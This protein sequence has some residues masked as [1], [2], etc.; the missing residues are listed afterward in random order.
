MGGGFGTGT[1][2]QATHPVAPPPV[3]APK[4]APAVQAPYMHD[5]S[6]LLSRVD[7][8]VGQSVLQR[9]VLSG[10]LGTS[11]ASDLTL[12]VPLTMMLVLQTV[13]TA[14]FKDERSR[15]SQA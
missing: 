2:A 11:N 6:I 7:R 3:Q 9:L 14:D 5:C 8:G 4:Q 13:K 1:L 12:Q 10:M 15:R